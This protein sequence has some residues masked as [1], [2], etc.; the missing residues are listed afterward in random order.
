MAKERLLQANRHLFHSLLPHPVVLYLKMWFL[1]Q[2]IKD[3]LFVTIKM[4][5]ARE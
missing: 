4:I 5:V 3:H 2:L 1:S